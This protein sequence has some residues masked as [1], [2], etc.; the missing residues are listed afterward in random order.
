[1]VL[2]IA[3][4]GVVAAFI[5]S[6]IVN[7]AFPNLQESFPSAGPAGISWVLNAY[8][9]VFAAFLVA[10]G[11]IADL[12]G[13]RRTF[14]WSLGLFTVASAACA[15]APTL[16]LLIAARV[17]QGLAAA[18]MVPASLG[19]VLAGFP[20]DRRHHAVALWSAAGAA[21]A[22]IGP[23]VGGLLIEAGNWR[24]VFLINLPLG[25]L[26]VRLAGRHLVESRAPGRRRSPDLV[27]SLLFAVGVAALLLGLVKGD[28]WGWMGIRVISSFAAAAIL[29]VLVVDH[30]MRRRDPLL[31]LVRFRS[32]S[33][34]NVAM[35]ALAAGFYGYALIN[36]MFLTSVWRYSI[37]EAGLA[38]TPGPV[39]AVV[40][41]ALSSK[42][43]E[44]ADPR[45]VLVPGCLIWAAGVLWM[46]NG[47]GTTPDFLG[48]WLPA[49]AV[50]GV[51]AG[52]AFPNF[53]AVGVAAAPSALFATASALNGVARQVGGAIGVAAAIALLD[54]G[55]PGD[56]LAAFHHAW[57]FAAICFGLAAAMCF[58]L[59][60]VEGGH[61]EGAPTLPSFAT[62]ARSVWTG[63][64][65][66]A[67]AFSPRSDARTAAPETAPHRAETVADFLAGV[68]MFRG[69]PPQALEQL[70]DHSRSLR[71]PAGEWLF[72]AGDPAD[73]LFV[74]RAGR[75]EV[76]GDEPDAP[77]LRELGRGDALGELALLTGEPRSASAR[78][79]RTSDL[80]GIQRADYDRLVKTLPAMSASIAT[81][82]ARQLRESRGTRPTARPLPSTIALVT[83]D[84]DVSLGRLGHDLTV[85]LRRHL[86][87]D[88][89]DRFAVFGN[90]VGE[91][92]PVLDQCEQAN[93]RTV[94]VGGHILNPDP[95]TRFCLQQ[96]DRIL[97]VTR[98]GPVPAG[99][100][101]PP[102]VIGC[103]L[104]SYDVRPGDGDLAPWVSTL[105]PVTTHTVDLQG[106]PAHGLDRLA[107]RLAGRSVGLVL[108]GGG[109]RAFSHIGVI[110]ELLSAGLVV[111]RVAGVSMGAYLGAMFAAGCGPDAMDA[112]CYEEFVRRQPLGD[113]TLPR[114]A[115]LRAERFT[116]MLERTFGN[117]AIEELQLSY[118]CASADLR[119]SE[120]VVERHGRVLDAVAASM[121][122]PLLGA[123]LVRGRQL[124]VDG[125][126]IDNLPVATLAALGE[127][128]IVAVDVKASAPPRRPPSA[129]PVTPGAHPSPA[130]RAAEATRS[131]V[132]ALRRRVAGGGR[133]TPPLLGETLTRL[134]LL[135]SS[136][137]TAAAARH[138][139]L[140]IAPKVP[141]IG[142]LEWHQ[143][144]AAV[145]AGREAARTAL[146]EAPSRVFN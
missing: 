118:L 144:D 4:L 11:R 38:L 143:I 21:A 9:I 59:G 127:G 106:A 142:L 16:G 54:P 62:S 80:I 97:V 93:D 61:A 30:L 122:I 113:Y 36:V 42:V 44:K 22:G 82:L 48:E 40:A 58:V 108:S 13:R 71:V 95:W 129:R 85:A 34:A 114:H 138:A 110:D 94:L 55:A 87:A 35:I 60:H 39:I 96:A 100:A 28:D 130:T 14:T 12:F 111:D 120:L 115:L 145:A 137:T 121:W 123:P 2:G 25:I 131:S 68:A 107:R 51:G 133:S 105:T 112:W 98:G 33:V 8:S 46:I 49:M 5:D 116:A 72:R 7:I 134:F 146:Q 63:T 83:V 50:L 18:L 43:T 141:G 56:G 128:P 119:A 90:D 92:G 79:V 24:L 45:I 1:M 41:A 86:R 126:L 26:G 19:L 81:T 69:L 53:A 20:A 23:S 135:A 136:N 76:V 3:S 91:F 47:V 103:D 117:L 109:A 64:L 132:S 125:S 17:V 124:L 89:L 77:V 73:G 84:R 99:V 15:A 27:G 52:M 67:P 102:E 66:V 140:V 29:A 104:V 139:D 57:V 32:V 78:V 101:V 10:G 6:T 37:V 74:I 65:V 31:E 70:A 75:I 88:L